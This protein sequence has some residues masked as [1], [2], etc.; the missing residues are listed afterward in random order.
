MEPLVGK[1]NCSLIRCEMY[2]LCDPEWKIAQMFVTYTEFGAK[3]SITA[4]CK[5]TGVLEL[6]KLV[7]SQSV[8]FTEFLCE[9]IFWCSLL[10]FFSH[11]AEL[12]LAFIS[13]L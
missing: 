6:S 9:S 10:L 3:T 2:E 4:I 12:W 5:R 1:F 13:F 11:K 7:S 8:L